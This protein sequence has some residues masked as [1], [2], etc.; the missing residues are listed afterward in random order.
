MGWPSIENRRWQ[1]RSHGTGPSI[2][3]SEMS[4]EKRKERERK[5]KEGAKVIGFGFGR[6]LDE[7]REPTVPVDPILWEGDGA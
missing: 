6:V 3:V 7:E 5:I 1:L 4:E 2:T